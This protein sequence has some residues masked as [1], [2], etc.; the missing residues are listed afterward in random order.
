MTGHSYQLVRASKKSLSLF[1]GK[2]LSLLE[3]SILLLISGLSYGHWSRLLH[4]M[5]DLHLPTGPK[6]QQDWWLPNQMN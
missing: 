2:I 3:A 1:K 5:G 6:T 4:H